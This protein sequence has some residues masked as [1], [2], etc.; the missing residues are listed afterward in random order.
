MLKFT[1]RRSSADHWE[2]A[3][4]VVGFENV[5]AAVDRR[6]SRLK[7]ERPVCIH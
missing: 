2:V 7:R 1:M 5:A 3:A 4:N 6:L